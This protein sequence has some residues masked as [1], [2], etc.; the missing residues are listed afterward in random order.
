MSQ[1]APKKASNVSKIE[2]GDMLAHWIENEVPLI[3]RL[4]GGTTVEGKLLY[5]THYEYAVQPGGKR[6]TILLHRK[7]IESVERK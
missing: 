3:F 5:Y 7:T 2:L 4:Q 6:P 1:D